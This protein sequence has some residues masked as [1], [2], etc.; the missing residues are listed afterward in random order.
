M[1]V[2]SFGRSPRRGA[3]ARPPFSAQFRQNRPTRAHGVPPE[4]YG[5]A[6]REAAT[7]VHELTEVRPAPLTAAALRM[8]SLTPP[9]APHDVERPIGAA[10]RSHE[11]K[12]GAVSAPAS[13]TSAATRH[14]ARSR[15]A[16]PRLFKFRGESGVGS[17]VT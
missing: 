12:V 10:R 15:H 17:R 6:L 1:D 14:V 16:P 9:L 5:L 8:P 7:Q 11:A 3:L 13:R 4:T 2:R